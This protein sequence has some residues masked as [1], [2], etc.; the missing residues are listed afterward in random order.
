MKAR[1]RYAFLPFG[2]GA[3]ICIGSAFATTEAVAILAVL[4]KATRAEMPGPIPTSVMR[5]TLHPSRPVSM[6]VPPRRHAGV[7]GVGTTPVSAAT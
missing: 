4:L 3:R 7:N 1:H 5:I 2:A 6:R